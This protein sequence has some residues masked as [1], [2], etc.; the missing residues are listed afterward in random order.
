M[1]PNC[2]SNAVKGSPKTDFCSSN[3][4]KG[5]LN[6]R[7]LGYLYRYSIWCRDCLMFLYLISQHPLLLKSKH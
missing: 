3:P 5:R 1:H 7:Q 2:S 6:W 4:N